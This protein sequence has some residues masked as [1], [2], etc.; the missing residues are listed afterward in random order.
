[1]ELSP[2]PNLWFDTS[3]TLGMLPYDDAMRLIERF[4]V[5][6]FMFGSDFPV[7]HPVREV[8]KVEKLP[9]SEG[10]L[11]L[12]FFGNAKRLFNLPNV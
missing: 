12:I 11:E 6:K 1:M 4:G 5:D 2:S 3:S 7:W 10:E 8:E 9:L